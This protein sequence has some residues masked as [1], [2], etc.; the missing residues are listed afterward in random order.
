MSCYIL[1]IKRVSTR[2]GGRNKHPNS[3]CCLWFSKKTTAGV[4]YKFV[5]LM[6]NAIMYYMPIYCEI[7]WISWECPFIHV[8]FMAFGNRQNVCQKCLP[9]QKTM[10]YKIAC[11]LRCGKREFDSLQLSQ[12]F[13]SQ[14]V[15]MWHTIN[16][17]PVQN[18]IF[19]KLHF[20]C[21]KHTCAM[22]TLL[23]FHSLWAKLP[24]DVWDKIVDLQRLKG[25]QNYHLRLLAPFLFNIRRHK[26]AIICP[27]CEIQNLVAWGW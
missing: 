7:V 13:G 26:K 2:L 9:P 5:E 18:Q 3:S 22:N 6:T 19:L 20:S 1:S 16:Q 10:Q 21:L 27:S 11:I 12:N 17:W 23:T 8:F 14:L 4:K 25:L 24:K 15:P